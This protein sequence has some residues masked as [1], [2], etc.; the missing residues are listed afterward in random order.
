MTTSNISNI[1]KYVAWMNLNPKKVN[2][3]VRAVYEFLLRKI[4]EPQRVEYVDAD[5]N[6][7]HK[8]VR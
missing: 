8:V 1:E 4:H 2:K 5:G 7:K 3:K 6:I